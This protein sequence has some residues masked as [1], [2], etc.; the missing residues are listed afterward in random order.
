MLYRMNLSVLTSKMR[1]VTIFRRVRVVAIKAYHLRHVR[2]PASPRV[3]AQLPLDGLKWNFIL[4]DFGKKKKCWETPNLVEIGQNVPG[5]LHED[6]CRPFYFC[7]QHYIATKALSSSEMVYGH[8]KSRGGIKIR[9]T[10]Q[11]H[12]PRTIKSEKK[13]NPRQAQPVLQKQRPQTAARTPQYTKIV[14]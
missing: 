8:Y 12:P 7:R 9:R 3:S 10:R 13:G 5:T 11:P 6:Q 14:N 2:P 1:I 4:E